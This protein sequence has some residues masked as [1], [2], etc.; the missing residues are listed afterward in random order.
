IELIRGNQLGVHGEGGRRRYIELSDLL[1]HITRH[2]LDGRLHFRHDTLGFLDTLHAA[3]AEPFMLGNGAKLLDV[4]LDSSGNEL[5]VAAHPA[6]EIDTMVVVADATQARL[7]LCTLLSETLV[8]TAGR[9]ERVLGVLQ[10]H[11]LFWAM[12]RTTLFGLVT[13]ALWV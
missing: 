12:A 4:P 6:L 10:A 11:G 7:D 1:S 3:L 8:L 9:F 13:C 5:A 2:K